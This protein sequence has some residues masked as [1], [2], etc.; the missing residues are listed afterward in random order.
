MKY[1]AHKNSGDGPITAPVVLIAESQ[2]QPLSSFLSSI[3]AS[4]E[5]FVVDDFD[6]PSR[7]YLYAWRISA[8]KIV[9]DMDSAK[10]IF[11]DRIRVVREGIFS[12]LDIQFTRSLE[13]GEGKDEIIAKK[14]ELRDLTSDPRIDKAKN[15]DD[16]AAAWP[17]HVLGK[18]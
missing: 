18:Y 3:P 16:L 17:S 14:Q 11:R 2:L 5:P 6:L 15:L 8:G 7:R 1:V 9:V 10:E 4:L 13:T 12:D